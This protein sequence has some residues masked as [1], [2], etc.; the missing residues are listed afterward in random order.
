MTQPLIL[1]PDI[2]AYVDARIAAGDFTTVD[3]AL[4]AAFDLLK[5]R[6][7]GRARMDAVIDE[8]F[9]SLKNGRTYSVEEA[10]DLIDGWIAEGKQPPSRDR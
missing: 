7:E 9:E 6:E 10:F 3:E 2:K 1:P 5:R 8:G 4:R